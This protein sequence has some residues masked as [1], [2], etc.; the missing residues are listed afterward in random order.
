MDAGLY[1]VGTPIGNLGDITLRALDVLRGADLILA[2]DTRHTRHLLLR[3]EIKT[4]LVSCHKFN[5]ASRVDRALRE[6]RE[7]GKAVALVT[8]AGMPGISDPGARVVAACREAGVRIEAIP[9]PS[10]VTT[11]L[12]LSGFECV[13]FVFGGFLPHKSGARRRRLQELTSNSNEPVVLFESPYRVERLLGEIADVLGGEREVFIA[14][15]MTKH[16]EETLRGPV[17]GLRERT[18]DRKWKGEVV[19]I[20]AAREKGAQAPEHGAREVD[21]PE[22]G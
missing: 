20:V 17:S 4:P 3:Y 15:E 19:V 22:V 12:A 5:E 1:L 2:E 16:F 21:T 18:R 14:R 11:A 9:G 6:I 8:D 13:G 10:A 7:Q